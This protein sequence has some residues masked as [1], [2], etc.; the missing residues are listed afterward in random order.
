MS[1]QRQGLC[2]AYGWSISRRDRLIVE[3]LTATAPLPGKNNDYI[4]YK[5]ERDDRRDLPYKKH[6]TLSLYIFTNRQNSG[7]KVVDTIMEYFGDSDAICNDLNLY[8]VENGG[9]GKYKFLSVDYRLLTGPEQLNLGSEG[10]IFQS[11]ALISYSYT[12][13]MDSTGISL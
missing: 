8:Q 5:M 11:L 10:G 13:P 12:Y 6:K 7:I 4:V 2:F 1:P 3:R 9:T